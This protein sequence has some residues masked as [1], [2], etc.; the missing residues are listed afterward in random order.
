MKIKLTEPPQR[1]CEIC[2]DDGLCLNSEKHPNYNDN[3]KDFFGTDYW[4][5]TEYI[6]KRGG[7]KVGTN[8]MEWSKRLKEKE[9]NNQCTGG[10]KEWNSSL[11]K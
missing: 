3:N 9:N 10:F 6:E 8:L 1:V 5:C 2:D 7:M 11:K 4:D